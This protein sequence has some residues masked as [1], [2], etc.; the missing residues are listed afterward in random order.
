MIRPRIAHLGKQIP[1]RQRI[2]GGA[3]R[4][5]GIRE[6]AACAAIN[7]SG[8]YD[9]AGE[10]WREPL[11]APNGL[12]YVC[13]G[14]RGLPIACPEIE[15]LTHTQDASLPP[16]DSSKAYALADGAGACSRYHPSG[17]PSLDNA[18]LICLRYTVETDFDGEIT[19]V[20]GIDADV[21]DIHG[22]HYTDIKLDSHADTLTPWPRPMRADGRRSAPVCAWI[23]SRSRTR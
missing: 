17:S 23:S 22:P 15:A 18:H 14:G 12:V 2:H 9:R 19:L 21:W 13:I 11:N 16:R 8:I 1:R 20:T 4:P 6:R 7:L 10:G 3:G 5:G